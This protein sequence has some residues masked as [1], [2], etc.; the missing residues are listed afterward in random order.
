MSNFKKPNLIAIRLLI[1]DLTV[2]L[3]MNVK[4]FDAFD[5]VLSNFH[6]YAYLN[7]QALFGA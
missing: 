3:N 1:V 4:I 7:Y 6:I 5:R 2:M